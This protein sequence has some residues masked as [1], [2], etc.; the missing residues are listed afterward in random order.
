MRFGV[1]GEFFVL[2]VFFPEG[3]G[4][5]RE[6]VVFDCGHVFAGEA[7]VVV[8]EVGVVGGEL[9]GG[10]LLVG[11]VF[12]FAV[13]WAGSRALF[14]QSVCSRGRRRGGSR[15]STCGGSRGRRANRYASRS[16]S[17]CGGAWW[18]RVGVGI[19]MF[20]YEVMSRACLG[21]RSEGGSR[22]DFKLVVG[23]G[24]LRVDSST[25]CCH[26]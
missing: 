11:V 25:R 18:P 12:S 13:F 6:P 19:G 23:V 24:R 10:G 22:V 20:Q 8:G 14:R 16:R 15:S 7:D 3:Y 21:V 17:V 26:V 2:E 4:V 1:P 9:E 5:V